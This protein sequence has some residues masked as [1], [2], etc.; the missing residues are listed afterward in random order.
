M[1]IVIKKI[2]TYLPEQ[3]IDNHYFEQRLDTSDEW[4]TKRTGIKTRRFTDKSVSEMAIKAVEEIIQGVDLAKIKLVLCATFSDREIMPNV[5]SKVANHFHIFGSIRTFD[6]NLACSGFV[7][8]VDMAEHFLNSGEQAILVASEDISSFMDFTDRSTSIL[9]G[10]GAGAVV[11]EKNSNPSPTHFG[12][13]PDH[14]YLGIEK[15]KIYMQGND[16]F[17]FAVG[18]LKTSISEL[19]LERLPFDYVVCHQ[20]N[21]RILNHVARAL[22]IEE[23]KFHANISE[24]G[25]TSA[26]SIPIC[27]GDMKQKGLL[28]GKKKMIICGFGAGLVYYSKYI[29]VDLND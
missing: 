27:L 26:A 20:A 8:A 4:I 10:D 5:S 1:G 23:D 17:K 21:I 25:N 7:A 6:I 13:E 2:G 3:I 11:L 28:S 22:E 24:V 18:A 19:L 12:L 9:F 15:G 29:E 16:V 14:K